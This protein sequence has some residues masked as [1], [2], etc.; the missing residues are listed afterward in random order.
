M[1]HKHWTVHYTNRNYLLWAWVPARP[2]LLVGPQKNL[3]LPGIK[4]EGAEE[5]EQKAE[6]QHL[7]G[8]HNLCPGSHTHLL[9]VAIL[10]G[11]P[12]PSH[13]GHSFTGNIICMFQNRLHSVL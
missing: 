4:G 6:R 11:T 8:S 13:P 2:A 12:P 1:V 9:R 7:W 3:Q 5:D 10:R